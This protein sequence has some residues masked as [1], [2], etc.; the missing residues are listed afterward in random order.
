SE[1]DLA[2]AAA[3]LAA[4]DLPVL[5]DIIEHSCFKMHACMMTSRPPIVYWRGA[6]LDVIHAVWR[7]RE[8]GLPGYVTSDAGPYVKVL[9]RA[10]HAEPLAA[11][12][13]E[14]AGVS[15]VDVLAPG[16]DPTVEVLP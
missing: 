11:V 9:C 16:P 8:A 15:E 10:D 12:L 2:A 7:A 4:R 5:G 14:V 3:A 1:A 13:R 6:T